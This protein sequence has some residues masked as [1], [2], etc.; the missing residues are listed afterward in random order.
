MANNKD[1][2][3]IAAMDL[4]HTNGYQATGLEDILT[5]SKVCKSN[6]YYHFKS[7]EELA[8]RVIEA[9]VKEMQ[10]KFLRPSLDNPKLSNKQK[11]LALFDRLLEFCEEQG[12]RKGCFFGNLGLELSDHSEELRRPLS[13]FFILLERKIEACLSDGI[14][15]CEFTMKGLSPQEL[16]QPIV[17]LLQGG[18]L[19]SK[20]HKQSSAMR[21][22]VKLI[23]YVLR[24]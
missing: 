11:V 6:F 21:S 14:S 13:E 7:K 12:C 23:G 24:E 15:N 18:L 3:L 19:L 5:S 4:F 9:K 2:I 1:K 22:T 10:E 16:A 20:T 8:I 17:A